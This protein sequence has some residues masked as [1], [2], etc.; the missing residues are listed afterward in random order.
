MGKLGKAIRETRKEK[1]LKVYE[2]AKKAGVN[3]VF[4]TQI[5]K[6]CRFPSEKVLDKIGKTLGCDFK[7]LYY[8]E[9]Y[10]DFVDYMTKRLTS[11]DSNKKKTK[12]SDL[13][14]YFDSKSISSLV[15]K[16]K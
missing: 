6:S 2:L 14:L 5:E 13:P 16:P 3:P 1:K 15:K 12:E 7:L 11:Y 4:I 8:A 9:K 10:P